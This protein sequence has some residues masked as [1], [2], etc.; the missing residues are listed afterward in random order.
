MLKLVVPCD[1]FLEL[2]CQGSRQRIRFERSTE[3]VDRSDKATEVSLP[4]ATWV[5]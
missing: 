5:F 1:Q 3:V 2:N 4:S